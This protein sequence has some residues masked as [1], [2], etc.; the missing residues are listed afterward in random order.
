MIFNK[1]NSN[2][3]YFILHPTVHNILYTPAI[4]CKVAVDAAFISADMVV[5]LYIMRSVRK[6]TFLIATPLLGNAQLNRDLLGAPI[7]A[8]SIALT[9]G[10]GCPQ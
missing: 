4:A 10:F 5:G 6:D 1:N 3:L 7:D 9:I 2:S 8:G